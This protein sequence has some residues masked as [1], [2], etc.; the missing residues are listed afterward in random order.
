MFI[1]GELVVEYIGQS[2]K[3]Q[4]HSISL[5][6]DSPFPPGWT[7]KDT[8]LLKKCCDVFCQGELS[9]AVLS[10]ELDNGIKVERIEAK[11]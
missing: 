11:I 3:K 8:N 1:N 5:M 9:H 4:V 6:D 2:S 10:V 7:E